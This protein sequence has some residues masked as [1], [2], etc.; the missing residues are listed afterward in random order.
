V[1]LTYRRY[2]PG[3]IDASGSVLFSLEKC[4]ARYLWLAILPALL[5]LP[6]CA[7]NK[8]EKNNDMKANLEPE[9]W[10]T[11]QILKNLQRGRP[12]TEQE[13]KALASRGSIQFDLDVKDTEEVQM[14]LQYFSMDKRGTMDKWLQ[15][16]EPHLPYVRAVLASY[17]LPPDLIVLP[18]IESGYSNLAY[19]PVGAGGMWQFMPYTGRRFGLT[20]DWWVD[21]RRDPYKATVA[22]AKYLTKLYQMFGDWHL[23]LAAYNAGEGKISRVM[24]ASGQCDFFDIAKDPKLLKEETRH[25]VPKFLAVLK[26]FQNL[27]TLGFKKINWQAGPNLKEVPAPGGT[28]LLALAQACGMP[29]EQFREYN[30]GFRRQVSPPDTTVNVYVPVAKEQTALAFLQNPGNFPA[31]GYQNY[32]AQPGDTWW[33]ISR[34]TGMPVAELRQLNAS[35]PETLP[36]G[37]TVRVAQSASA[38]DNT[39]LA[40]GPDACA[41]RPLTAS[42]KPQRHRVNKGES[43]GSIAKK[44]GVSTKELMAANKMKHEGRLTLGSWVVIPGGQPPAAPQ[45]AAG[46]ATPAPFVAAAA[47]Q[48]A[49]GSHTVLRGESVTGIAG[50]YG[51]SPAELMAANHMR[52]AKDLQAGKKLVIP[53]KGGAKPPVKAAPEPV[54]FAAASSKAAPSKAAPGGKPAS[55]EPIPD[56]KTPKPLAQAQVPPTPAKPQAAAGKPQAPAKA[57]TKAVN[58]KVGPGD[59]VWGIAKKFNVEPSAVMA[60]NNMKSPGALQAGSELTIHKD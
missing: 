37:Q 56:P 20:V 38:A 25:Y 8:Y 15:R 43:V 32:A 27:D 19:S 57:A 46:K 7:G 16:A 6:G 50:K 40:E 4:M 5:L 11:S 39:A 54:L 58:Y 48:V 2:F 53:G 18:F 31:A 22:A 59:T 60:W 23:A 17:N 34:K 47:P 33:N 30:P 10:D 51:I 26:I 29:W 55:R 13:K 1:W 12:L 14:F 41:P 45:V 49:D 9:V 21:E 42:A 24:A 52:S 36:P 3:A 35:L 44:Y 28:D